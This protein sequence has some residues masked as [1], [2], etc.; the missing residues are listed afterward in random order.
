[1][2]NWHTPTYISFLWPAPIFILFIFVEIL[3]PL[4]LGDNL[5]L[6]ETFYCNLSVSIL[7]LLG[8]TSLVFS[9]IPDPFHSMMIL[10]VLCALILKFLS[11][12]LLLYM[13]V[14]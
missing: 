6:E 10:L 11:G 12:F 1:M 4:P 9:V 5:F 14:C 2:S 13:S 7:V 3:I 8:Y